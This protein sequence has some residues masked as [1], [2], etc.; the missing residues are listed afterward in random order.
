MSSTAVQAYLTPEEY[1]TWERKSEFKN[2]YLQGHIVAMSGA[3]YQHTTIIT[4]QYTIAGKLYSQLRGR[5]NVQSIPTIC[6]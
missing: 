2:E 3:S 1:L 4:M 6:A 5:S